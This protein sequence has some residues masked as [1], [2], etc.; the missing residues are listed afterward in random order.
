MTANFLILKQKYIKKSHH[1]L[2]KNLLKYIKS[3]KK[4]NI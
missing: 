4:A 3:N 2:L 1:K